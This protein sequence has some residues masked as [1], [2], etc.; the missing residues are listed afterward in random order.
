M[1]VA[2]SVRGLVDVHY[3]VAPPR[4]EQVM[5]SKGLLGGPWSGWSVARALED[6]DRDGVAVS[7]A[8][9]TTPAS[10]FD[11]DRQ[12]CSLARDCNEYMATLAATHRGRFGAFAT[13][14]LPDIDGRLHEIE[15][16]STSLISTEF[17]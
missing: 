8:S 2:A 13:L 1:I 10:G 16:A 7:I 17:V 4:W 6:M 14:P 12:A 9:I 11:N 5:L 15:F 3:H